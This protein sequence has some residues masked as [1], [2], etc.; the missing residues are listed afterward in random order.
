[1]VTGSRWHSPIFHALI[2]FRIIRD[3][4]STPKKDLVTF[5]VLFAIPT[6]CFEGIRKDD[7]F[8]A[9]RKPM[10]VSSWAT[11]Q[12]QRLN[13]FRPF[14]LHKHRQLVYLW[15]TTLDRLDVFCW[16]KRELGFFGHSLGRKN[17]LESWWCI[18][19][20]VISNPTR[21]LRAV[22][23]IHGDQEVIRCLLIVPFPESALNE[24]AGKLFMESYEEYADHARMV[25]ATHLA[26]ATHS[27][28]PRSICCGCEIS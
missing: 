24:E 13:N 23:K 17:H 12:A 27:T 26:W 8:P 5:S 15:K 25:S 16:Y 1:M 14:R 19:F 22:R 7:I 28:D 11:H 18:C 6:Y 9:E 3:F 2:S 21:T 20:H 4:W 10:T